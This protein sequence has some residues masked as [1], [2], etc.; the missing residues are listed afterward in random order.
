MRHTARYGHA[1]ETEG[2]TTSTGSPKA[3][4]CATRVPE[5]LTLLVKHLARQAAR[6][7]FEAWQSDLSLPGKTASE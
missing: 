7:A 4:P 1:G 2:A 5:V 3:E 6:E